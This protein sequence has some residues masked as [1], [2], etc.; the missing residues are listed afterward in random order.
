VPGNSTKSISSFEDVMTDKVSLIALGNPSVPVGQY[1]QEIFEFL[2]GW[3]AVSKKASLGTNV[4]EVLSQV[5]TASVDCGVVYATDAAT[6]KNVKVV[7][8]APDGS[9]KP[10]LYPAA[11]LKGSANAKAAQAFLDFLSTPKAVAVFEK[12]GFEVVK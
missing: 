6:A 5:E 7:A 12:I 4:K 11:V 2:K 10:V 3:E 8:N 9:H 1:S